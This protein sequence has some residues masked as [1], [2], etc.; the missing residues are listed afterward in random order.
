MTNTND[1]T[2]AGSLRW[3]ITEANKTD[4]ADKIVFKIGSGAQTIAVTGGLPNISKPVS[5]DGTT[6][7]G[8]TGSTLITLDAKNHNN[9]CMRVYA[10]STLKALTIVN[11]TNGAVYLDIAHDSVLDTI[12]A[13]APNASAYTGGGLEIGRSNRAVI[14]NCSAKYRVKGIF[15][16]S[17][18]DVTV[19]DND[20]TGSGNGAYGNAALMFQEMSALAMQGGVKVSGNTFG[21]SA[22][23]LFVKT[24]GD[25]FIRDSAVDGAN[26]V[27]EKTKGFG[28]GTAIAMYV[29]DSTNV[30]IKGIDLSS[31]DPNAQKGTGLSTSGNTGLK[32]DGVSAKYRQTGLRL[33]GTDITL[34][35]SDVTDSGN[36]SN[37][38]S[39]LWLESIKADK[40]A[41][42]VKIAGNTFGTKG[43]QLMMRTMK[44][45]VIRGSAVDDA[46]IVLE[47]AKGFGAAANQAA[48]IQTSTNVDIK[49]LDVSWSNAAEQKG[50]GMQL[51]NC[52]NA[53]VETVTAKYRQSGLWFSGNTDLTLV[54]NDM[55][56]S[57]NCS[58]GSSALWLEAAKAD[59]VAG[60]IKLT[61]TTFGTKGCQVMIRN[62]KD[63]VVRGSDVDNATLVF[64][65]S[66]G[67]GTASS[68]A[69]N[70][71]NSTGM[72]IKGLKLQ[73]AA[74]TGVGIQLTSCTDSRVAG[75]EAVGVKTGLSINSSPGTAV[76]CSTFTGCTTAVT[77]NIG[78][79]AIRS[80]SFSGNTKAIA[81]P[82]SGV[83]VDAT[84]NWW[85]QANGSQTNGGSGD[86]HSGVVD[87]S[88]HL[89]A[90]AACIAA[91]KCTQAA[92]CDDG[93]PCTTDSC[94]A[95]GA[96]KFAANLAGCTKPMYRLFR[97]DGA[98]AGDHRLETAATAITGYT[99]EG[100]TMLLYKQQYA[101]MMPLYQGYHA[102][103]FDHMTSHTTTEDT[104]AHSG[105]KLLGYCAT[106]KLPWADQPVYRMFTDNSPVEY[107]HM[108]VTSDAHKAAA[109]Q[110]GFTVEKTH[111]YARL[112]DPN[113]CSSCGN[114]STTCG[115][116]CVDTQ[117][118]FNNCGECGKK[119][120]AGDVCSGGVCAANSGP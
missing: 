105:Y 78:P 91:G 116:A 58:N 21:A 118:D 82:S 59:K 10:R 31:A 5:I 41:G 73:T 11:A 56:D 34:I 74:K 7:P 60:G 86:A 87:G 24:R 51:S 92:D 84:K 71:Q 14:K 4:A 64:E 22:T 89:T 81:G 45:V 6:Q 57:G 97:T 102:G 27:V 108:T 15:V 62:L 70:I 113:D 101:G 49:G 96:C 18:K 8:F 30:D 42:G 67:F 115:T 29:Q 69:L 2:N 35:N 48:N 52:T 40:L 88:S 119:C 33:V 75:I 80:C 65:H 98:K 66:K 39:A 26:I 46:N 77:V 107:N 1:D 38:S 23:H 12:A 72:D 90:A 61:G 32:L 85:G 104:P 25:L 100:V 109:I 50:T 3:A 47:K 76:S 19:Q 111:C 36:C 9:W 53:K 20:L 17:G 44:D 16:H 28:P 99:A 13:D 54:D 68:T 43:C 110:A 112:C 37:G 94:E 117:L 79:A 114:N 55:T 83:G 106:S 120:N 93:N 63:Q 103:V 95:G